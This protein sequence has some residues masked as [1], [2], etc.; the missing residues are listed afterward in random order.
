M[1][2]PCNNWTLKAE[3]LSSRYNWTCLALIYSIKARL[4]LKM[5][6]QSW[7][8][9]NL[10]FQ[11]TRWALLW[12]LSLCLQ[13]IVFLYIHI[14]INYFY[15]LFYIYYL[16][17]YYIVF[18]YIYIIIYYLYYYFYCHSL[19]IRIFRCANIRA[20]SLGALC[21]VHC[22]AS[23]ARV[24]AFLRRELFKNLFFS[25]QVKKYRKCPA[26]LNYILFPRQAHPS[27]GNVI[28]ILVFFQSWFFSNL[29]FFYN[30]GFFQSGGSSS[31][32]VDMAI[33]SRCNHTISDYGTFGVWSAILAGNNNI[34]NNKTNHNNYIITHECRTGIIVPMFSLY[35]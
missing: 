20:G 22:A 25:Q 28:E 10:D 30:L 18:S 19:L 11:T 23:T 31:P 7:K 13:Y 9:T 32:G 15:Y 12:C 2:A 34:H 3:N 35:F 5:N 29:C 16:Y 14:I 33:L 26:L 27:L 24:R 1:V 6:K 17:F 21:T 8:K 4:P